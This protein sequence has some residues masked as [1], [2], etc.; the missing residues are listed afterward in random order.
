MSF[1]KGL[2]EY[3]EKLRLGLVK[4]SKR[5]NP[6]EK[7]EQNPSSLKY[8]IHAMCFD[9]SGFEK[10]DVKNCEFKECQFYIHRPWK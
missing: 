3:Q 8:A 2:S 9:C 5:L 7:F 4:K 1:N 10:A 6:T